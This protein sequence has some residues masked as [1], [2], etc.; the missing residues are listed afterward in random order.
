MK[1]KRIIICAIVGIASIALITCALAAIYHHHKV[2]SAGR[3]T[4]PAKLEAVPA[5]EI[6]AR[7]MSGQISAMQ[8]WVTEV[9]TPKDIQI[10]Q[11]VTAAVQQTGQLWQ[12][13]QDLINSSKVKLEPRQGTNMASGVW[14]SPDRKTEIAL[15][16]RSPKRWISQCDKRIY[17]PSGEL[18]AVL[19][20]Y[21]SP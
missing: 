5:P 12:E 15:T 11:T 9:N 4:Q 14:K 6:P 13:G 10:A 1:R 3:V 2:L 8:Q 19:F 18:R 21:I 16:I 7:D 17:A 20:P